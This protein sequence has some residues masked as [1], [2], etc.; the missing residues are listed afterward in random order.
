MKRLIRFALSQLVWLIAMVYLYVTNW[1][2]TSMDTGNSA[3]MRLFAIA[4]FIILVNMAI[5]FSRGFSFRDS[6]FDEQQDSQRETQQ[7]TQTNPASDVE[8]RKRETLDNVLRDLS[9]E[10]LDTLRRR[11]QDGTI[12]DDLL[13]RRIVGADGE[14][15]R[16]G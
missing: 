11:L 7:Q 10:Q 8:K 1:T 13:E 16:Q 12:D 15:I 9:D 4:A 5:W 2:I 6:A 14:F 3:G